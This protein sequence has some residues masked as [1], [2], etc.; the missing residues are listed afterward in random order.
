MKRNFKILGLSL[1]FVFFFNICFA[2]VIDKYNPSQPPLEVENKEFLY[3]IL[4]KD[5]DATV[6]GKIHL[7]NIS[8]KEIKKIKIEIPG[9]NQRLINALQE[10]WEKDK[11][12]PSYAPL[13]WKEDKKKKGVYEFEFKKPIPS[14]GKSALLLYYKLKNVAQKRGGIWR[15]EIETIKIPYDLKKIRVAINVE[16]GLYL[17]TEVRPVFAKE[18]TLF[19]PS[20]LK[21]KEYLQ[22]EVRPGHPLQKRLW[23]FSSGIEYASGKKVEEFENIDPQE[24]VKVKGVYATQRILLYFWESL[25]LFIVLLL[26]GGMIYSKW[27]ALKEEGK[28]TIGGEV[29]P[30]AFWSSIGL[31]IFSIF[32]S[33]A[34][35]KI[36][37]IFPPRENLFN[38]LVFTIVVILSALTYL[39]FFL[40][41][42]VSIAKRKKRFL[43][44]VL[45]FILIL[46][47]I[48]FFGILIGSF[49]YFGSWP[50]PEPIYYKYLD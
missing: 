39:F 2:R 12:Q 6:S 14:Q 45:T 43:H 27:K 38:L 28:P 5:G 25:V 10:V 9:K 42:P 50:G 31:I 48:I 19:V 34:W 17:K 49:G 41:P 22:E 13:E 20:A 3:V 15:F 32:L 24:S 16:R 37:K 35:E 8:T 47:F 44:G 1:I 4:G 40:Y 7:E 33:W 29:V 46:I 21:S 18:I 26:I 11:S 23:N 36:L 30:L